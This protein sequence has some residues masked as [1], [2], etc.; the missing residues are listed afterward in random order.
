[1]LAQEV[2][3]DIVSAWHGMGWLSRGVL[4]LIP[5][6]ALLAAIVVIRVLLSKA[7]RD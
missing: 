4:F 7:T 3:F 1:V 2:G 5:L 6:L